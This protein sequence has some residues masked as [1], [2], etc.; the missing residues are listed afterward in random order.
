[1]TREQIVPSLREAL[2][3]GRPKQRDKE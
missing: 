3:E 1:V 2:A